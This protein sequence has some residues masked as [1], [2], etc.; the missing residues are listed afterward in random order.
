MADY[1][2]SIG[3]ADELTTNYER[4]Q[5]NKAAKE[6]LGPD[7]KWEGIK[8][9]ASDVMSPFALKRAWDRRESQFREEPAW[10]ISEE[11][12]TDLMHEYNQDEV[13]QLSESTSEAEFLA[14]KRYIQED[15]DRLYAKSALGLTGI[16][17]DIA[18]SAMDPV[19]WGLG[20]ITGGLGVGAKS[21]GIAKAAKIALATGVENAAVEQILAMGDTQHQGI[22]TVMAFAT[23]AAIGGAMSPFIR[24]KKPGKAALAD[25]ADDAFRMD[26]ENYVTGEA[27]NGVPRKPTNLDTYK[28][29]RY[30]NAKSIELER[31]YNSKATWD[32]KKFGEAKKRVQEIDREIE[33]MKFKEAGPEKALGKVRDEQR[34]FI[35]EVQPE[36]EA[37]KARYAETEM[38]LREKIDKLDKKLQE[39]DTPKTQAKLWK[40]ETE[41]RE[42]AEKMTK[43]IADL[44]SK[45]KGRIHK[46]EYKLRRAL[47]A[48]AELKVGRRDE[49]LTERLGLMKDIDTA[50]KAGRA[51]K[52]LNMW[53]RM[54]R[55]QRAKQ[56]FGDDLPTLDAEVA[57]QN[58]GRADFDPK[59]NAKVHETVDVDDEGIITESKT[60]PFGSAGAAAAGFRPLHKLFDV[61]VPM[62]QVIS[63]FAFDGGKVPKALEGWSVLP[64]FT[65][66]AHSPFTRLSKSDNMAIRGLNYHLLSAGQGGPAN[67]TGAAAVWSDIYSKQFRSALKNR[68]AD[69]MDMYRAE[70]NISRMKMLFKPEV[71]HQFYKDIITEVK[72]PGSISSEGVRL[73]AEGCRDF[74]EVAGKSMKNKGVYGFENL[75][76]DRNYFS[77][78]VDEVRVADHCHSHGIDKV[79]ALLSEA[80]QRGE[81]KLSKEIA[82]YVARGYVARSLDHSLKMAEFPTKVKD[83]DIDRMVEG[84]KKAGVPDDVIEMFIYE[85]AESNLTQGMSNRAKK[86]LLP[87]LQTELNGLKM[88]DLI[89]SDVPKLLEAYTREAAG[90]SAMSKLGFKTRREAKEF[91][92]ELKKDAYNQGFNR[93]ETDAEIQI[94]SDCI[95]MIYGRSI[96]KNPGSP[97]VKNLSRVRDFTSMVRLQTMGLSTIPE[98]ARVTAKRGLGA[99]MEAIPDIGVF[100]TKGLRAGKKWSG[101]LTNPKLKELEEMFYIT[102]EDHILYPGYLRIDNIEES[103]TYK[104]LGSYVDNCLAQGRK[105]QEV[106]SAF[107]YIQGSGE[108]LSL[109][110]L[111]NKM[112]RWADD[113]IDLNSFLTQ[114]DINDAGWHDGFLDQV[115]EWMQA[116]PKTEMYEGKEIRLFNIGKM[117]LEMR[118]RIVLGLH[119]LT[120]R[121]MQRPMIGELP[122]W[123]N[124]WFGSTA[125]QFR[126]FSLLSLNKQLIHDIRHDQMAGAIIAMHSMFLSFV[127]YGAKTMYNGIG[128]DQSYYQQ[129]FSPSGLTFGLL[130]NMGQL[131]SVGLVGDMM[132]TL[133][134]MPSNWMA[135]PGKSGFRAMSAESVPIVGMGTDILKT[136]RSI[137][138]LDVEKTIKDVH[139]IVPFGKAAGIHQALNAI[140]G[141]LD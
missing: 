106:I 136:A 58:K 76:L 135:S 62:R 122:T 64:K 77:T 123:M 118:E 111:S 52:E 19:S 59:M 67:P 23:G 48:K 97:F 16:A 139:K 8:A 130:N 10:Q 2:D 84:L 55:E 81:Y 12:K 83:V 72:Y 74:F 138:D 29:N 121:D 15:R 100:G 5:A 11:L 65:Q 86:S 45:L 3:Q 140:S 114:A 46:A 60:A 25:E 90:S 57:R 113:Q 1:Y 61:N 137:S 104:S 9:S 32:G 109:N 101:E 31:A 115:K 22:D 47:N 98:I 51:G 69:G 44:E 36:R 126:N 82:D 14:K 41:L 116:N 30:V 18:F 39:K 129:A 66:W 26:A 50:I 7:Y 78:I 128:K 107:R 75:E 120:M 96:E 117:P 71:T 92:V 38:K 85:S 73:A 99:V 80:Y 133:G 110:A 4:F 93:Q 105:Y 24:A 43:E 49:L 112:K 70:N 34:A 28:I 95:D 134:A 13:K 63:R 37:I 79:Q 102:G 54:S 68:V 88:I 53:N 131:A 6:A 132:S 20:L 21:A 56:I 108:R 33:I 103:A 127:A 94:L 87:D 119:Q 91:L 89:E 125:T 141:A 40:A 27:L 124:K 17:A 35:K 42:A